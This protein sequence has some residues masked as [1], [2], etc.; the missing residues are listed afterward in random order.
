MFQADHTDKE[1]LI[2]WLLSF[3]DKAELLEPK[4]I[5]EEMGSSIECMKTKYE[6][7]VSIM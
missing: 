3:R 5:R 4:E 7:C 1:D 2:T 6:D